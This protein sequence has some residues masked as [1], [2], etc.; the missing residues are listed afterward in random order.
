VL[1]AYA[2]DSGF[3]V[4]CDARRPD[5]IEIWYSVLAA[6]HSY[7]FATR[8]KLLTWQE[9][10]ATLPHDLQQFLEVKYGILPADRHYSRKTSGVRG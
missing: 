3:C 1:A 9:L 7:T 5:L 8:L 4:L 10:A 6:V 2:S